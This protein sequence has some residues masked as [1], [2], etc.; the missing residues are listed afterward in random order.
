MTRAIVA[1]LASVMFTGCAHWS[2]PSQGSCSRE[3]P[4]KG[5][6][7]SMYY[8]MPTDTYYYV[9]RAELCFEAP[10]IARRHGYARTP[11]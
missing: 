4:V 9:T 5:N 1:A 11:R 6:A 2:F 10:V 7:D 3:H 8:H